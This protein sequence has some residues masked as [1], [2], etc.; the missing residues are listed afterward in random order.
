[1]AGQDENPGGIPDGVN[2]AVPNGA[3]IYDYMLGGKDNYEADRRAADQ[4]IAANP[5]APLTA[6]ANRGFLG[7]AVRH[8]AADRGIRQF[9]DIGAGLPTQQN[10]HQV[11]Q[12]AAPGSR[13]V[14]ADYDPVVVAHA[15]ALLATTD[16][17]RV[18]KGDLRRPREILGDPGT[19]ALL[20]FTEPVA[21]LLVAI[22]HFIGPDEDPHGI[23]AS[24]RDAL[25]SGSH[26]VVS[27][28]VSDSPDE[29]MAAAQ[30]GFRASGAPL[31]P[32][33][34]AEI[35]RF[36]DGFDLIEPGLADVRTWRADDAPADLPDLPWTMVGAVG[37]LRP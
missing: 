26:L 31:T 34:R 7:R 30:R 9:I 13:V 2:A 17:V 25:P 22:L 12:A 37:R 10:V 35:E 21:V 20:D 33:T 16:H 11:A 23:V 32:R 3:R 19:R 4:M 6:Q 18:I 5:A 29:V 36:F 8:L 27:H 15:D 28:T 24:L 1:M 14:Y